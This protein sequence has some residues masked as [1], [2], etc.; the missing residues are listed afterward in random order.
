MH[1]LRL[2]LSVKIRMNLEQFP[3]TI[4]DVFHNCWSFKNKTGYEE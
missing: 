1:N 4:I 3:A 2:K